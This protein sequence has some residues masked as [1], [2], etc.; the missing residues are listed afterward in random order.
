MPE[1]T[2]GFVIDAEKCQGCLACMRSCP[3][4]AIRVKDRKASVREDHCI[5]CGACLTS[6]PWNAINATTWSVDDLSR[7]RFKV[8]V[9]CPVLFGQF[10]AGVTPAMIVE[11]LRTLGF[12]AVWD[13]AVDTGLAARAIR[14]YVERW[15]GAGP[16]ISITCP[17]VVRLVQVSYPN[18]VD[19]LLPVQLGREMAGREAKRRYAAELG[20]SEDAVGA[21]YI[22]PC[23]AKSISI[24]EPAEGVRSYLDGSLGIS[25]VYNPIF[26]YASSHKNSD[27]GSSQ[28]SIV[29]NSTFLDLHV[30]EGLGHLLDAHRCLRVTGLSNIIE[31]FDDVE[32][33]KLRNVDFVEAYSCRSGCTAGNLTVANVYVARSRIHDLI[34]GLPPMD[35]ETEAEIERRY[36]LE[37]F[38]LD[39]PIRPRPIRGRTGSLKERIRMI[40]QTEATLAGLPGLDCGLCGAPTCKDLARDIS[41]GDARSDEC[42]FLSTER[43]LTLRRA[44]LSR[45]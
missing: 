1:R 7:F 20:L 5:D 26:A 43:L 40:G 21:I 2:Q 33:G 9:P 22:T 30:N 34:Q 37:N 32:K 28:P 13:Y 23:Q 15:T 39:R 27:V 19:R 45:A 31:V 16:L 36:P 44:Y 11:G 18:M 12:D 17:V 10:P 38:A 41:M 29:L 24:L 42:V 6:C 35:A 4:H 8:A 25:D 3:T 14:S